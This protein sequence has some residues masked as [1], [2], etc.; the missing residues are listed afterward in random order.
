VAF[1]LKSVPC[2]EQLDK[3]MIPRLLQQIPAR[4]IV[5][6]FPARSLGGRQKGMAQFYSTHFEA[7]VKDL[8]FKLDQF[9]F[10]EEIV[11]L[12]RRTA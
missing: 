10:P 12:L 7:L 1:L 5:V 4:S 11:Y 8:P 6:S 3:Q 2:L 9:T